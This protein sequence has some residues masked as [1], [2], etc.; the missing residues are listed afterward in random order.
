MNNKG[1]QI[2]RLYKQINELENKLN[3]QSLQYWQTSYEATENILEDGKA[4]YTVLDTFRNESLTVVQQWAGNILLERPD[5]IVLIDQ[6]KARAIEM[7]TVV[8]DL[9]E[10]SV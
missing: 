7:D 10:D 9:I 8:S 5:A 4:N 2:D 3:R 6:I 1:K